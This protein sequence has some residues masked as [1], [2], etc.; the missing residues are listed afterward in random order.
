MSERKSLDTICATLAYALGVD[1]PEHAAEKNEALAEYIDKELDG[2][3]VDRVF[4]YNP[5][6]VAEW[7][8]KK[9]PQLV[10]EVVAKTD[11]Q[12][13]LETV[14]PSVTP[15]CF[16]TM[17][18]GA[19]PA[20]HGVQKYE[21]VTIPTDSLF[22]AVARSGKRVALLVRTNCSMSKLYLNRNIDYYIYDTIPE[23]NAKAAEVIIKDEYDLV[24]VYNGNY[25]TLMHKHGPESLEAL[26]ELRANSHYFATF[27]SL[28]EEHW[29]GHDTLLG[30]AMDHGCHE[31]DGG[32]GSHGLDMDEDLQITHFYKIKKSV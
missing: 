15:V 17:Y 13:P 30:F 7:I 23:I 32:A 31:I 5:D 10:T 6:A 20:V 16:A 25:D 4:M 9:Y 28:I 26:S 8:Y 11:L 22:D 18:T 21:K 1:A 27:Y 12:L 29:A 24:V 3:K 2:K 19:Q 14:M